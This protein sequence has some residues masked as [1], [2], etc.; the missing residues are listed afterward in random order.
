MRRRAFLGGTLALGGC[1]L[2]ELN[3]GI[4][5]I[6]TQTLYRYSDD[7]DP[8]LRRPIV[9]VPG[10]LGSRLRVGREGEFLWGGPRRLS[11]NPTD[12]DDARQLALPIGDGS[13]PLRDLRD[14]VRTDG[15]LRRANARL[16]FGTVEEEVY[17]GLVMALNAG[18]YEFSRTEEEERARRGEN[19]GS[20]EFP[21]DWRRDIVEAAHELD[22]FIERKAEQVSR[23]RTARYG[24]AL[25]P[26]QIRFD[27]IA[28]SMG[29]L[30]VRYWMM[31][32]AQDLPEDGSL[33]ELTWAGAR[34]AAC[35]VYVAPPNLGSV[36]AFTSI[37]RGRSFG[38]LQP[39]YPPG[40][41]GTHVS[42]YQLMPRTRHGRIRT[43]EGEGRSIGDIYD[44]ALWDDR[45]WGL[46]DP[47]EDAFLA[48][49]LP[50]AGTRTARRGLARRHLERVLKRAEQ[51]QRAIDRP[52]TPRATDLFLVVGTGRDTP[53]AAVLPSAPGGEVTLLEEEG[54]GVVLRASAL[55]EDDQGGH[56]ADGPR[57][58]IRYRTVLLLPDDHVSLTRNVVFADNL[59]Y[60]LLDAPRRR[61]REPA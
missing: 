24:S 32:G 38:P 7:L 56:R 37:T 5:G 3:P 48:R 21:Y 39:V 31:Y 51:F 6:T 43:G 25:P 15:V 29:S 13:E 49:L 40:L 61:V 42:T 10:I 18:G 35:V 26:D 16:L 36:T 19:P 1:G 41:I 23:V 34:R 59:H 55:S 58:P 57:R 46:L 8:A 53:A 12:T 14:G 11:L 47:A 52:G 33:P 44:A 17:D 27:F 22:D 20:L 60:W 30:V 45:G 9:T 28:H 50:D 2:S 4:E 54:D